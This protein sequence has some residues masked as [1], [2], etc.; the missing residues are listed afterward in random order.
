MIKHVYEVRKHVIEYSHDSECDWYEHI[1]TFPSKEEANRCIEYLNNKDSK[2]FV[3]HPAFNDIKCF[4]DEKEE[5]ELLK[6]DWFY[7][8]RERNAFS[9][10][11]EWREQYV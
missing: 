7:D 2:N 4:V 9:S 11:S 6:V 1:G 10:F 8:M 5:D 3:A